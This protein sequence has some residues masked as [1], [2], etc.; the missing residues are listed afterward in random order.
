MVLASAG[1]WME[2]TITLAKA[3]LGRTVRL[4]EGL[5]L[6]RGFRSRGNPRCHL[7]LDRSMSI[8]NS[9]FRKLYLRATLYGIPDFLAAA[10]LRFKDRRLLESQ[11]SRRPVRAKEMKPSM[12]SRERQS[13][14]KKIYQE[15][16]KKSRARNSITSHG[17][18]DAYVQIK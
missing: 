14:C 13:R 7:L 2:G 18:L 3:I 12:I 9:N 16:R 17:R 4:S 8:N 15:E 1:C 6:G 5:E 10:M 11:A